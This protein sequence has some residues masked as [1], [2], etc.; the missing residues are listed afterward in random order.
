MAIIKT[1]YDLREIKL[2]FSP[3]G[4][5]SDVTLVV[6]YNL[7]DDTANEVLAQR[8]LAK[9]IWASLTPPQRTQLDLLGKRFKILA[10]AF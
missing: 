1:D 5:V 3:A 10:E 4:D 6:A 2:A 8:G 9:S 7:K